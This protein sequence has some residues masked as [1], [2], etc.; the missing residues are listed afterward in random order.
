MNMQFDP[1]EPQSLCPPSQGSLPVLFKS[2][3]ASK[4]S[5]SVLLSWETASEQD[6]A[7]F[8]IERKLENGNFEKIGFVASKAN[9]GTG[10]GFTYQFEDNQLQ[11]GKSLYRLRQVDINGTSSY[12]D[13]KVVLTGNGTLKVLTYPNPNNGRFSIVLPSGTGNTD[14]RLERL[15][16]ELVQ[17]WNNNTSTTIQVSNLTKGFYLLRG[18]VQATGESFVERVVVQ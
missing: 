3:D 10:T 17:Q 6:N 15:S 2:F 7:G 16:G 12:S 14:V 1:G 9:A 8:E 4:K 18:K 13:V 5:N 11:R